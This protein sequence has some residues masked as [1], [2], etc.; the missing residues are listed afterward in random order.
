VG[1]GGE[2]EKKCKFTQQMGWT[3]TRAIDD[4]RVKWFLNIFLCFKMPNSQLTDGWR[5]GE[6]Y[7]NVLN[8]ENINNG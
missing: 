1:K 3:S 8:D 6:C 4:D 5:A 7:K 2:G